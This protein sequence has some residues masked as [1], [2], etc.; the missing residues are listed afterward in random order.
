MERLKDKI[1]VE[2]HELE[3]LNR[4]YYIWFKKHK[5][6]SR[7]VSGRISAYETVLKWIDEIEQQ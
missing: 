2:I 4:D 3:S 6:G 5:N 7:Y 1:K